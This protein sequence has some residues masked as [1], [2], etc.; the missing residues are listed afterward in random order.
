MCEDS[1]FVCLQKHNLESVDQLQSKVVDP[2]NK[3]LGMD[4]LRIV[5][6]KGYVTVRCVK[7]CLFNLNYTREKN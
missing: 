7:D 3:E 1:F 4:T 6:T 5:E 2:M